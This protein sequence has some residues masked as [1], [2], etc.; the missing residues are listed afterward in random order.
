MAFGP[1]WVRR[2]VSSFFEYETPRMVHIKSKTIGISAR[3]VE[4]GILVFV[5]GYM[6]YYCKGYQH[7][8]RVK[9]V[10]TSK[11]KGVIFTDF[12]RSEEW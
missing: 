7:S 9:S 4:L 10:V 5:F 8:D 2:V 3:L 12:N 6:L 1:I 11:V